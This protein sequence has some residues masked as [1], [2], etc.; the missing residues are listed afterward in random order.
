VPLAHLHC[1]LGWL[2]IA[3]RF[4]LPVLESERSLSAFA[5]PVEDR[6]GKQTN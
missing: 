3:A 6:S 2:D 5:D 4:L 1:T